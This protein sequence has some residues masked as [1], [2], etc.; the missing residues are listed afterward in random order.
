MAHEIESAMFVHKPAWHG[1]GTLLDN[2]PT[3]EAAIKA[4]GLDWEVKLV[5]LQ[6]ADDKQTVTQKAVRRSS[7]SS[8]LGVVGPDFEPLQNKDAFGWFDP[9]ISSKGAMFESAGSLREGR[10]V[11]ILAKLNRDPMF[12]LP[13]DEVEKYLLLAHGHDGSLSV[14]AGFT[15]IRV[16][17]ANTLRM[18]AEHGDSKLLRIKHTKNVRETLQEVQAI[19][20]LADA[21]F[22]ATAEQYRVLARRRIDQAGLRKYVDVVWRMPKAVGPAEQEEKVEPVAE[23]IHKKVTELFEVGRGAELRGVRGTWWGAYNAVN[24][25]LAHERGNDDARRLD[26]LWFGNGAMLNR[27]ALNV[28]VKMAA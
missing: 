1:L 11:W 10:R 15:P 23:R 25:F 7:D 24:E 16:V 19:I 5:D 27:R 18:A 13:G 20:D 28:A 17:C 14:H 26:S 8:V 9:F 12:V 4:A 6:T 2:P 21:R 3:A 22:E